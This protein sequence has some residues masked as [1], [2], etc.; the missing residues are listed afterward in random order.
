MS[1][2]DVDIANEALQLLGQPRR[3]ESLTQDHPNARTMNAAFVRTRQSLLRRYEW[4]FAKMRASVAAD[5]DQ[6][7]WGEHNRYTLPNAFLRLSRDNET[8]FSVDW[9]IEGAFIV[10]DDDSPLEFIYIADMT[11][12]NAFDAL[13]REAFANRLAFVTCKEITGSTDLHRV[14]NKDYDDVIGEAKLANA[15]E[16]PAQKLDDEDDSWLLARH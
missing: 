9:K 12:A 1:T 11:D 16:K 8:G 14:I 3:L 13:F 2:S 5:P 7:V 10:T 6:T 4:S 15:I